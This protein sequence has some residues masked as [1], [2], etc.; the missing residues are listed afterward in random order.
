M[1]RTQSPL[2]MI[3][4]VFDKLNRAYF[5]CLENEANSSQVSTCMIYGFIH[6]RIYCFSNYSGEWNSFAFHV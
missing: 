2:A 6:L 3:S 5:A 1:P 4:K